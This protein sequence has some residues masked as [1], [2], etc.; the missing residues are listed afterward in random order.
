MFYTKRERPDDEIFPWD[1]IDAGV[2]RRFLLEEWHRALS[3][4]ISPNC[5]QGCRGCGAFR[6]GTGIC[7]GAEV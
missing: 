4:E 6:F 3:G 5:R 1:M 2:D 7:P